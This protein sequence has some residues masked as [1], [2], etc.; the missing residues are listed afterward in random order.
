[1][2][3]EELKWEAHRKYIDIQFVSKG[4]EQIGIEDINKVPHLTEYDKEKDVQFFIGGGNHFP[5]IEK[6]FAIIFPHEVH[7]PGIAITKKSEV[8]KVV[9]KV[10]VV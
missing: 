8:I 9:I 4:F 5:L 6:T 3:A 1:Q 2:S 10:R 7:K